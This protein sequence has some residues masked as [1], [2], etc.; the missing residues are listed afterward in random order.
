MIPIRYK[1]I[2]HGVRLIFSEEGILGMYKGFGLYQVSML[3]KL[4]LLYNCK[5]L[6]GEL[7]RF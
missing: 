3:A 6:M 7:N 4:G 2:W 1:S 5:P